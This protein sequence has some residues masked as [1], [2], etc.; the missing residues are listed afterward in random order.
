M[1]EAQILAWFYRQSLCAFE[2]KQYDVADF[3]LQAGILLMRAMSA[4]VKHKATQGT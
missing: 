2:A 1:D 3:Y 4:M